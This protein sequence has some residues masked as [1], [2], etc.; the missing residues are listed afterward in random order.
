MFSISL[1]CFFR[2]SVKFSPFVSIFPAPLLEELSSLL[3]VKLLISW[4]Y[5]LYLN[6]D[7]HKKRE[8]THIFKV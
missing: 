3:V 6:E 2:L 4:I 8:L 1:A 7:T 5:N